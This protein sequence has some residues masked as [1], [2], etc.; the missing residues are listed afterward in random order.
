[1]QAADRANLRISS[2]LLSLAR[3]ID[4]ALER[5]AG[6]CMSPRSPQVVIDRDYVLAAGGLLRRV[7]DD[8]ALRM[9]VRAL[10]L[11]PGSPSMSYYS[12][13]NEEE[14]S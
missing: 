3:V 8:L 11:R 13:S 14:P 12:V 10:E 5:A 4:P 6:S 1:M 9:L 2:K 7:D